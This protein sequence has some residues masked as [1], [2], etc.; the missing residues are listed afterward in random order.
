[1][2]RIET[3]TID[4]SNKT[5]WTFVEVETSDGVIGTG[6]ATLYGQEEA[7][8]CIARDL[9]RKLIGGPEIAIESLVGETSGATDRI[10][11]AVISAIE[12]ADWKI[13]VIGTK[14]TGWPSSTTGTKSRRVGPPRHAAGV[15]VQPRPG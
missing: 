1:M 2:R 12:A 6:E 15:A 7:M 9:A 8:A 13:A 10:R 14:P 3:V 4:V 11:R 5:D